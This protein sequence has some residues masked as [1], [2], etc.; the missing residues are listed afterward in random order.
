MLM[1]KEIINFGRKGPD[2]TLQTMPHTRLPYTLS[3]VCF[4]VE[5]EGVIVLPVR[6]QES[7][8]YNYL[9][10]PCRCDDLPVFLSPF[11][12]YYR[13][14]RYRPFFLSLYFLGACCLFCVV[15]SLALHGLPFLARF[16]FHL[17]YFP[18][19]SLSG[20][21]VPSISI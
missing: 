14:F 17:F 2:K 6:P 20:E 7:I 18:S 3:R 10:L 4:L 1:L 16:S 12:S 21:A 11:P 15:F 9:T 8:P 5:L 19:L 13:V